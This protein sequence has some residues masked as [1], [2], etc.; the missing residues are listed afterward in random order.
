MQ[1]F[2]KFTSQVWLISKLLEDVHTEKKKVNE[3]KRTWGGAANWKQQLQL[4]QVE[5]NE[6]VWSSDNQGSLQQNDSSFF[7]KVSRLKRYAIESYYDWEFE[8]PKQKQKQKPWWYAKYKQPQ[9]PMFIVPGYEL[10][11]HQSR[12][13]RS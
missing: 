6:A 5:K 9:Q 12:G 13:S 3:K 4:K 11:S 1:R 2:R 7:S 8:K 10:S